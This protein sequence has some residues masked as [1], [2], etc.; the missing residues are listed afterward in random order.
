MNMV[1]IDEA[2][3]VTPESWA[4]IGES[5]RLVHIPSNRTIKVVKVDPPHLTAIVEASVAKLTAKASPSPA[6]PQS[7]TDDAPR[8]PD[9]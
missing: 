4:A 5:A 2:G 6:K 9:T 7:S 8:N 3:D 1:V